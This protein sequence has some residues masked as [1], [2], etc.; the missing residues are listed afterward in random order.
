MCSQEALTGSTRNFPME[1]FPKSALEYH[2]REL[3]LRLLFTARKN[4]DSGVLAVS[5]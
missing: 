5:G 3:V 4:S 2:I 1:F